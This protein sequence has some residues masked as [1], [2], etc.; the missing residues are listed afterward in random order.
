M[1]R[2]LFITIFIVLASDSCLGAVGEKEPDHMV[3]TGKTE[4]CSDIRAISNSLSVQGIDVEEE[5]G[6]EKN[7]TMIFLSCLM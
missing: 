3:V 1:R 7:L 6:V 5:L 4:A 2:C